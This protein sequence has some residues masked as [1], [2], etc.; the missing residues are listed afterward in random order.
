LHDDMLALELVAEGLYLPTS[1]RFLD[2][3]TILVL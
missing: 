2:D 1:M 3:G